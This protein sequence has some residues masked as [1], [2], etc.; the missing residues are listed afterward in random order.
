M[1]ITTLD[2]VR[3]V[4]VMGILLANIVAFGLPEAAYFSPLAWGGSS[5][6]NRL[7]WLLNV[8]FVEG[9]MRGLFSLLFGASMLLV[10]E[11]AEAVGNDPARIHL[12]RMFWLFVIGCVHLYLFWWGDI[13]AHYALVGTIALAFHRLPARTLVLLAAAV[14]ALA[15]LWGAMGAVALFAS[16]ARATPTQVATWQA[17]SYAFGTPPRAHLLAEIAAMRGSFLDGAAWRWSTAM[18]PFAFLAVGGAETLSAMLLGMAAY[19]SGFVTGGWSNTTYRTVALLGIGVATLG[20]G[21]L[22]ALTLAHG[23]DQRWV[24]TAAMVASAP[25]RVAGFLGYAALLVLL[26]GRGGALVARLAAV[27]R[28][29]FSN[30]LGTTLMM[31]LVFTGWGLAQF[32]RIDR[33]ALYLM[34]PPVWALML[35]WSPWWLQRFAYGPFEWLWRSLAR[36]RPQPVR[37]AS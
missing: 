20:Y 24:Y 27:G 16:S 8:V 18:N 34:V 10:I 28:M 12:A 14:L 1:R 7:A 32:A 31:D 29:A 36:G 4:A 5:G 21:G 25:F 22:A 17:F 35:L 2:A 23:F 11:R 6:A 3:G 9:R 33:A 37:R 15:V 30:Y 26:C 13:L 19:R